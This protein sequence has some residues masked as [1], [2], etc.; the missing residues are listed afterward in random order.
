V[1]LAEAQ[2]AL[3]RPELA[4]E[5][6]PGGLEREDDGFEEEV[7]LE[8]EAEFAA[9]DDGPAAPGA[10]ARRGD[11]AAEEPHAVVP[12]AKVSIFRRVVNFLQGSWS[13]L[14]RVQWPDRRQVVQATGVVIGFVIVAGVYLGVAD[15]LAGKL[16]N[17]ILK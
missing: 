11:G 4:A 2:M 17:F 7:E 5:E 15:Y 8:A 14:H 9:G 13:E 10:V 3:G 12:A 16:M 6:Q 1:E